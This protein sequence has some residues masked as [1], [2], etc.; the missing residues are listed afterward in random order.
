[1]TLQ[2]A[3][4]PPKT[5]WV[6]PLEL[7]DL[8]GAKRIAIDLETRDPDLKTKGPGWATN[9]GEICGYAIATEDWQG[10]VPIAHFGGGQHRQAHCQQMDDQVIKVAVREG[11]AQRP[12]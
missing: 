5:E 6:P 8:S 1:M 7:P 2:M 10:Y 9:N 11:H 12:I 4:F 3:M